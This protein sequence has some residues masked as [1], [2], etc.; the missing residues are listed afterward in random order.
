MNVFDDDASVSEPVTPGASSTSIP[1]MSSKSARIRA[2]RA[3]Q[4]VSPEEREKLKTG[5]ARQETWKPIHL[6]SATEVLSLFRDVVDGLAFLVSIF[7]I[8]LRFA[9]I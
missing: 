8:V 3:M 4:K 1:N 6:L 5:K 9:Q 7:A 2:F